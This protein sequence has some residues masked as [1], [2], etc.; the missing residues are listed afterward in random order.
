M[1][2]ARITIVTLTAALL[3][4]T[5]ISVEQDRT[6]VSNTVLIR[7]M[8][9]NSACEVAPVWQ[10]KLPHHHGD[11]YITPLPKHKKIYVTEN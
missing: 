9:D 7:A 1:K 2:L 4:V 6:I 10:G 8:R 5:A 3:A 11:M